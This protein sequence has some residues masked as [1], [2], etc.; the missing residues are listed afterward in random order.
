MMLRLLGMPLKFNFQKH[1][2]AVD[3]VPSSADVL[4]Y[5]SLSKKLLVTMRG[6]SINFG[7]TDITETS[8]ARKLLV[9]QR[10]ACLRLPWP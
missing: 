5:T 9:A 10:Q 1:C 8:T 4:I 6:N 2:L 3:A 7:M